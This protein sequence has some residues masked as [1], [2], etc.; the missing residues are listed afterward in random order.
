MFMGILVQETAQF[1]LIITDAPDIA[2]AVR[3]QNKTG[4]RQTR[5]YVQRRMAAVNRRRLRRLRKG[6]T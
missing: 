3:L 5:T 2:D 4:G 1:L 6:A